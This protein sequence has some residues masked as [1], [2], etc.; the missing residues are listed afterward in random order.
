MGSEPAEVYCDGGCVTRNPSSLGG[1]F[2][3]CWVDARGE[4]VGHAAGH[5]TAGEVGLPAVSNNVAELVAAVAGLEPLP[6]GWSGTLYTDSH[7]TLLRVNGARP[8]NRMAKMRGIP[9]WLQERLV[10]AVARLGAFRLV[11]LAGHPSK[12]ALARGRGKGGMPVSAHNVFVDGLC[13]EE[14]KRV[15]RLVRKGV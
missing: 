8:G 10:K 4:R 9:A 15:L 6:D 13:R 2:A 3:A 7:V 1:T 11:L 12:K 14:A 5:V